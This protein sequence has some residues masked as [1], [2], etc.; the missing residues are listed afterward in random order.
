MT[1]K[2]IQNQG[3]VVNLT[4]FGIY[5]RETNTK[6][7]LNFLFKIHRPVTLVEVEE[8]TGLSNEQIRK[9]VS[10]LNGMDKITKRY[11]YGLAKRRSPP[12]RLL[13]ISLND[14]QTINAKR[15]LDKHNKLKKILGGF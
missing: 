15:V 5:A 4:N 2:L 3:N 6:K 7:V 12:R 13:W 9:V 14:S 10:F 1:K 11:Q 8:D